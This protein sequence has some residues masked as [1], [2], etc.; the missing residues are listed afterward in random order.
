MTSREVRT[1]FQVFH[2]TAPAAILVLAPD[3]PR[4]TILAASD[5][6]LPIPTSCSAT[7]A[8]R[9]WTCTRSCGRC[10]QTPSSAGSGSS[11]SAATPS[12]RTS[13]RRR[14]PGST[15]ISPNRRASSPSSERWQRWGHPSARS[16]E[17]GFPLIWSGPTGT[18]A[19]HQGRR[20]PPWPTTFRT[21]SRSR[22]VSNGF[23]QRGSGTRAR[24][25]RARSVTAPPV[26]HADR[27]EAIGFRA[28]PGKSNGAGAG[29][30]A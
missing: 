20:S 7:S 16:G 13:R 9:A 12:P 3:R 14:L 15:R 2:E 6:Y 30:E 18:C 5:A 11:R 4:F 24:N 25:S 17:G 26:N 21:V 8:C 29:N 1:A 27:G 22:C 19:A 23:S 28:A 10:A